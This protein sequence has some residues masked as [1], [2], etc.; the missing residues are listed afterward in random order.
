MKNKKKLKGYKIVWACDFCSEEFKTKKEA[1][2]HEKK[3]K[4]NN[5]TKKLKV[6]WKKFFIV[7]L[8]IIIILF[9]YL[10]STSPKTSCSR[11]KLYPMPSEFERAL[12]LIYQ[13][14]GEHVK[15]GEDGN[16]L[17]YCLDVQYGDLRSQNAEGIF[18]FDKNST[19]NDLKIIVDRNYQSY[20]DILTAVLLSHEMAHASQFLSQSENISNKIDCYE[21]EVQAFISQMSLIAVLNPE[22]AESLVYRV[23][24]NPTKN[25]A[26]SILDTLF[27]INK[28]L[29][30]VCGNPMSTDLSDPRN[31]AYSDC[32]FGNREKML[33][34]MVRNSPEYQKQCNVY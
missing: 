4:K 9:A 22:E 31:K 6:N 32:F 24:N 13:R 2:K 11:K 28:Q 16:A 18:L 20:D 34:K 26:Y 33:E 14:M 10:N 17:K 23:D 27:S 21:Q 30:D 25:N 3:C 7:S 5:I 12:S 1:D 19:K 8:T 29:V 15:I